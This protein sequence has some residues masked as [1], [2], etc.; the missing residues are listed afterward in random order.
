MEPQSI[1]NDLLEL[2]A[3]AEGLKQWSQ[4]LRKKLDKMEEP[5]KGIGGRSEAV[6]K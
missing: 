3:Y 2:E 4:K 5:K 1:I 6:G